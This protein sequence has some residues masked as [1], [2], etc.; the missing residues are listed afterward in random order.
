MGCLPVENGRYLTDSVGFELCSTPWPS[1]P[2]KTNTRWS[3]PRRRAGGEG[4][5]GPDHLPPKT[6]IDRIPAGRAER[7]R[8]FKKLRE[9]APAWLKETWAASERRGTDKLTMRQIDAEIAA[10]R[11]GRR[12]AESKRSAWNAARRARHQP[13]KR[14][15]VTQC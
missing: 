8:F 11:R 2:S 3:S 6:V 1:S 9:E 12:R 13:P 5:T 14:R 10:A 4:G 7:E 15:D